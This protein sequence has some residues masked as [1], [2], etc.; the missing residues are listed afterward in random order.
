MKNIIHLSS[1][2]QDKEIKDA[3]EQISTRLSMINLGYL[4]ENVESMAKT[5]VFE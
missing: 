3:W 2:P 1:C 4:A 5:L